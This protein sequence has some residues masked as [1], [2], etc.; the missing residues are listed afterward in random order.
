VVDVVTAPA[1]VAERLRV[2]R[3]ALARQPLLSGCSTYTVR[4]MAAVT[5]EVHVTAGD[6]IV[7]QGRHGLW[8]FMI[9]EGRAERVVN[10]HVERILG[11]G[12]YF[13]EDAV[14]RQVPQP[15]SIR[16]LSDMTLFVVGCQRLVPLVRDVRPLRLRLGDVVT[17]PRPVTMPFI[18]VEKTWHTH[19]PASKQPPPLLPPRRLRR[20]VVLGAAAA[21]IGSATVWHPPVAVVAPGSAIDISGDITVTGAPTTAVHGRYLV[22]TV[23]VRQPTLLGLALSLRH[24][25]RRVVGIDEVIPPGTDSATLRR[26]GAAA[27]V[28]SQRDG[29]LAGM[30][31][32]GVR[33]TVRVRPRAVSGPSAGLA[34]AL[35]VEDILDPV[36]R[37]AGRNIAVTGSVSQ[38]G[39]V[40]PVGYVG[41][42]AAG[43]SAADASVFLVPDVE[44]T[45][46]WGKGVEVRGVGSLA[47]ALAALR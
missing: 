40:G 42:K 23:R 14:L 24:P 33:A 11:P 38:T 25:N 8:F 34:Y 27:F 4:R 10:G 15:A 31:A 37:A 26:S 12:A 21:A 29:A 44:A 19:P 46:A 20:W 32:A 39:T 17:R 28:T 43:A 18:G 3:A 16:A 6:V 41:Q 2:K 36:D 5:D 35:A 47:D 22:P 7:E 45:E 30:A 13:G 1:P 9:E